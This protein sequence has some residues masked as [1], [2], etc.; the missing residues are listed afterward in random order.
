MQKVV[1]AHR[2]ILGY[3]ILI[4]D[5]GNVFG[6]VQLPKQVLPWLHFH[7]TVCVQRW[8]KEST[9]EWEEQ[10]WAVKNQL[11]FYGVVENRIHHRFE[12]EYLCQSNQY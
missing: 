12:Y 7:H 1:H 5:I 4:V 8:V 2:Q 10:V 6:N 11:L 3:F 9:V